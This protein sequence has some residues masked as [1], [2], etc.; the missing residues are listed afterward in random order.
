MFKRLVQLESRASKA[1]IDKFDMLTWRVLFNSGLART[2]RTS[3][4][5]RQGV[6]QPLRK[7]FAPLLAARLASTNVK[8]GK[9]HQVIGAVVD[10]KSTA[11]SVVNLEC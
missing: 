10:G 7:N 9:I 11:P 1:S 4:L 8:E 3:V 6:A 2:I 5:S